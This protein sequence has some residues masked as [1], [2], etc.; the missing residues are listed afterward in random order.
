MGGALEALRTRLG[1]SITSGLDGA[2]DALEPAQAA[3]LGAAA[4][5][6]GIAVVQY[7]AKLEKD[8]KTAEPAIG[9]VLKD[10]KMMS[11]TAISCAKAVGT[12]SDFFL[13]VRKA[14]ADAT[15]KK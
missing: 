15:A 8:K 11:K 9:V 6:M 3:P 10:L 2:L 7:R 13:A 1:P 5:A 4:T 14:L 12:F